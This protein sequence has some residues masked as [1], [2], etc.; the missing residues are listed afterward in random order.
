MDGT[1]F[2]DTST[3]KASQGL[4]LRKSKKRVTVSQQLYEGIVP[5]NQAL[6]K[7]ELLLGTY[8]AGTKFVIGYIYANLFK[9]FTSN[10]LPNF[11]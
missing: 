1:R 4:N 10:F 2:H 8:A 7:T 5:P 11:S 9:M 3:K 6:S